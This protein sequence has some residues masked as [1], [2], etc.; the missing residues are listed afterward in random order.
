MLQ[1]RVISCDCVF[2]KKPPHSFTFRN[3]FLGAIVHVAHVNESIRE[4]ERACEQ[5]FSYT[6]GYE[7]IFR[8]LH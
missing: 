4:E 7:M 3:D 2:G 8:C 5:L 1:T 6:V